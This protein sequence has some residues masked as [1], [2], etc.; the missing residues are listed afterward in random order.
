MTKEGPLHYPRLA[1]RA[2][3]SGLATTVGRA[4]RKEDDRWRL[5]MQSEFSL[6]RTGP[7]LD[8]EIGQYAS[9][10]ELSSLAGSATFRQE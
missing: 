9:E 2:L 5:H 10:S 7:T 1:I 8:R 4:T 3:A 6:S